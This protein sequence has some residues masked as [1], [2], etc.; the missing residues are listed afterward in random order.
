MRTLWEDAKLKVRNGITT[1]SE[2]LR[3]VYT[4]GYEYRR[5]T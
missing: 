5:I 1:Y 2:I 4:E 3:T